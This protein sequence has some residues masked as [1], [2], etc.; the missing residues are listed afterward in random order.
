[1]SLVPIHVVYM[2]NPFLAWKSTCKDKL[3]ERVINS[4]I[5]VRTKLVYVLNR[6]TEGKLYPSSPLEAHKNHTLVTHVVGVDQVGL[7]S[8]C[9]NQKKAKII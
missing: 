9:E 6:N 1:M 7:V 2:A 5:A 8:I 4:A 3:N